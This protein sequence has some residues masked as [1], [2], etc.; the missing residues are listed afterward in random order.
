MVPGELYFMIKILTQTFFLSKEEGG[1]RQVQ[2]YTNTLLFI[3]FL[4]NPKKSY[5]S[6]QDM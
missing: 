6:C 1:E 3:C 2:S 5:G 4:N